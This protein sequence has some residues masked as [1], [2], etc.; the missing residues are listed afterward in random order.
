MDWVTTTQVLDDLASSGENAAWKRFNEHFHGVVV[1]F[2]RH[3]GLSAADAEDA[4]QETMLAFVKAFRAGKYDRQKGRLRDW[5]FGVAKHAML[6]VRREQ[7]REQLVADATS[8]TSF[9]DMVKDESEIERAWQDEWRKM[10]LAACLEQAKREIEPTVFAAFEL[11]AMG[12]ESV[13]KV[14]EQ[15][16]M[17]RNAVYIAKSRVLTRLRELEKQFE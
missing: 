17:S 3:G 8:G 1:R 9:W 7:P 6:G 13:E 12:E 5:L 11:Y 14:A 2:A 4:A 16:K 15:L 10:A